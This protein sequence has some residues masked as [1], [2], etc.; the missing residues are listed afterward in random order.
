LG[1]YGAIVGPV[2]YH[3]GKSTGWK[4]AGSVLAEADLKSTVVA[5]DNVRWANAV[6]NRFDWMS[7]FRRVSQRNPL[8]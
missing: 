1:N 3:F 2:R 8:I 6:N 4:G 5:L 7:A